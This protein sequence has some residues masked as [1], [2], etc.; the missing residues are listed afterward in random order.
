M[1]RRD[2]IRQS[3]LL[4]LGAPLLAACETP[5]TPLARA[6]A[7]EEI[8]TAV[9]PTLERLYRDV[10]GARQTANRA[11]AMLVFP[12]VLRAGAGLGGEYGKGAL[13]VG[14]RSTDYYSYGGGSL[15]IQLGAERR[16]IVFM[17]LTQDALNRFRAG[18]GWTFGAETSVATPE[19]GL[20]AQ[21]SNA[22]TPVVAYLFGN[23]GLM[24]NA[25]VEGTKVSK[26]DI[27]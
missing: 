20:A 14:G 25:S 9:G 7:R 10:P 17:F 19:S 11:V 21:T 2:F 26:L 16:S 5:Q 13:R 24:F 12:S 15:G 27:R 8:D 18:D 4:A 3:A 23:T 6:A 1:L 22:A